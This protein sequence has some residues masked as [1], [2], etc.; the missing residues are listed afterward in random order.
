MSALSSGNDSKYEF[1]TGKDDLLKKDLV[2]KA[3]TMRRFDYSPLSKILK[4]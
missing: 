4:A 1:L 2:E 3:A